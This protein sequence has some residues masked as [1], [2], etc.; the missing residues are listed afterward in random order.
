MSKS[1]SSSVPVVGIDLGGT[2][3]QVGVVGG[4][5][6]I[7]GRSR[8]KT[9]AER[10]F[11][12][13]VDRMGEAVAEAC[14]EAGVAVEGLSGIGVGSPGAIDF[15]R[16][17]VVEAPNLVWNNVPLAAELSRRCA[18]RPVL[19]DN[20]VNVA[21]YG[22]NRLGAGENARD[23]LGVWVGTGI[24]G[25]LVLNGSMYYGAFGSAGEIGHVLVFPTIQLGERKLEEICSRTFL[26]RRLVRL[27]R[28]NHASS[29]ASLPPERLDNLTAGDLCDAYVAGD[30]LTRRVIDETADLL[31][32][33]IANVVTLLALP[34]VILGGGLTE[35]LGEAYVRR[36]EAS[37][38]RSVFPAACRACRVVPTRLAD[39][40]GLLGAAM[41][42]RDRFGG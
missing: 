2:N 7:L 4:R 6:E 15:E 32:V 21:V 38:R 33:A 17:V 1:S 24:G 8:R 39:N 40:A 9:E 10:G 16:G 37:M 30:E 3:M 41:L 29:L 25:G 36:V 12:A 20:D 35:S 34:L 26:S 13:V 28:S 31:G 22:E 19:V 27:I 23:C 11:V 18:G 5:G 14:A 42:A